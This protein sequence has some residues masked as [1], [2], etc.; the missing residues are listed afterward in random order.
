MRTRPLDFDRSP[1]S[2]ASSP[3]AEPGASP[4]IFS[5]GES[6]K[7]FTE[8]V[9][10]STLT[11]TAPA[12]AAFGASSEALDTAARSVGGSF[13]LQPSAAAKASAASQ[14]TFDAFTGLAMIIGVPPYALAP[15]RF[16][17][18]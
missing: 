4:S 9:G 1:R 2:I 7:N 15:E 3:L 14:R 11:V 18:G 12:V 5:S 17:F 10:V 13:L 8:L 6:I 16:Q